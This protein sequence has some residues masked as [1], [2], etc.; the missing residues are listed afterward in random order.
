MGFHL[1]LAVIVIYSRNNDCFFFFFLIGGIMTVNNKGNT[2]I[3][4]TF[5]LHFCMV[6]RI[7]INT[8]LIINVVYHLQRHIL[9]RPDN[10]QVI[11]T[12]KD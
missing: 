9:M 1:S 6:Y 2:H 4:I 3:C 12:K 11:T 10:V 7:N 8:V 5:K